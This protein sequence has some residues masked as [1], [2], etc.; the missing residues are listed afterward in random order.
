M[1]FFTNFVCANYKDFGI[2]DITDIHK[3]L[4]KKHDMK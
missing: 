2:S 1:I 3:F 4:M